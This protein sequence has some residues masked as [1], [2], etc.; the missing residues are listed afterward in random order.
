MTDF[1][2]IVVLSYRAGAHNRSELF[3]R[4]LNSLMESTTYPYELILVDNT[5]NNRGL[6]RGRNYGLSQASGKYF[7]FA[8]DDILFLPEWLEQ[9]VSLIELGDKY[10]ATPIHPQYR[11]GK[12]ELPPVRGY[13]QNTRVGS[14][15]LVMRREAYTDI[16][17]FSEGW[18]VPYDIAKAGKHFCNQQTLKGYTVLM[19]KEPRAFD[20]GFQKH[21]YDIQNS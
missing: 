9:C 14:N 4:C 7:C 15:C 11:I 16:G 6:S 5:H 21:S 20:M 10:M 17:G 3:R 8:D 12:W 1:V 2:S 18:E 13:R 19:T